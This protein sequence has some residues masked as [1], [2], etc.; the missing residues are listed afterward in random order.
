MWALR[1]P[2]ESW[3]HCLVLITC[4]GTGSL[5]GPWFRALEE[6]DRAFSEHPSFP[7][8]SCFASPLSPFLLEML[9]PPG[10]ARLPWLLSAVAEPRAGVGAWQLKD[11]V[12]M[13]CSSSLWGELQQEGFGG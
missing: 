7:A 3:S 4:T 12:L 10:S 9:A 5:R 6:L 8:E 13:H 1:G 2:G 11:F